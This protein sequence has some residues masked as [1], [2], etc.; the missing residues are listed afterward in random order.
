[1]KTDKE[2]PL[3]SVIVPVYNVKEYLYKCILSICRQSYKNLQ[4]ILVDDGS[5]DGSSFICDHFSAKDERVEVIHKENGG[6]V[7]ARKA[8]ASKAIGKY[9]AFVDGDDWIDEN[10][11]EE[12][13]HIKA[14]IC[15]E[16]FPD[17]IAFGCVEEYGLYQNEKK[18][19]IKKGL[20][21][22]KSLEQLVRNI[23][24]TDVFFEWTIL[25]HLCDKLLNRE[26]FIRCIAE[27]PDTISFAEDAVSS[28]LC[29]AN[30]DSIMAIDSTPYHY[31]QREGSI[32]KQCGEIEK[33]RF[34]EIYKLLRRT[35]PMP[36]GELQIK[37]YM[38]FLLCLKGYSKIDEML[39]FP[40]DSV[41]QGDRVLVYGA[42][43]F[44]RIVK[45]YVEHSDEICLSGWTD[46]R[47]DQYIKQG[48]V[49][50]RLEVIFTN[51]YDRLVISIL[52]E[53]I[54]E[55][56]KR[57]LVSQGVRADKI[58]FVRKENLK[59]AKLPFWLV[60]NI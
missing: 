5:T 10:A 9:I 26:L 57:D 7:S 19:K 50:D 53:N 23:P 44:G 48:M 49:M 56:V 37:Y 18:N 20:Y 31:R 6:L 14:E 60:E 4:I 2:V 34:R 30:A 55:K 45:E 16:D 17:I 51:S 21:S 36:Y 13:L 3:I 43:G 25:P 15:G 33:E 47:A 42:G 32:V 52:N 12:V 11:Y 1:M 58:D 38:F 54:G 22:G 29:M 59:N 8:G 39:L 28:F 35:L 27:I 46:K 40:F 24:M 41:R